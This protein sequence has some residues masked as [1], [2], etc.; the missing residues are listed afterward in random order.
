M[1]H[2]HLTNVAGML[3]VAVVLAHTAVVDTDKA[4]AL[5]VEG[6]VIAVG[7]ALAAV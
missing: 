6:I 5:A 7:I 2:P 4:A 3:V 1:E